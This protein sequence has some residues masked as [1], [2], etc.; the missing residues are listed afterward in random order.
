MWS[1]LTTLGLARTVHDGQQS[2]ASPWTLTSRETSQVGT[3]GHA[4]LN[5]AEC[6]VTNPPPSVVQKSLVNRREYDV[7]NAARRMS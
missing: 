1:V 4:L 5:V 3:T 7:V 6:E 2:E